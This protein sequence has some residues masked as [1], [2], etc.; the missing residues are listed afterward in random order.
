MQ[1]VLLYLLLTVLFSCNTKEKGNQKTDVKYQDSLAVFDFINQGNEVYKR[2]DNN[3]SFTESMDWYDKA[4]TAAENS[5]DSL[6]IAAA[7]YAKGRAYDALNTNPQKT[8]DYFTEAARLYAKFPE[9]EARALYIKHLVAHSYDKVNDSANCVN[10]LNNLFAEINNKPDSI[11]QKYPFTAEMALISTVVRNYN[12]ADTILTNL[13]KRQWIKNDS[14]EY[15]YVNHYY[16]TKARIDVFGKKKKN[17]LYLDSLQTVLRQAK[18]LSDSVFYSN[19]LVEMYEQIGDQNKTNF[20]LRLYQNAYNK[21]H[22]PDKLRIAEDKLSKLET[23]RIEDKRK[24]AEDAAEKRQRYNFFLVGL[25]SIISIL[26]VF[27]YKRNVMV[28]KKNKETELLNKELGIK[29]EQNEFLNKEIHH[30]VKN[31]LQMVMSLVEMEERHTES[32]EVK[33]KMQNIGLR[34]ESIS[35][36]HQQLM[37]QTDV[38][39]LKEYIGLIVKNITSVI[40]DGKKLILNLDVQDIRVPKKISLPL[41]L[42]INEWITNSIKYAQ[43]KDETIELKLDIHNGNNQVSVNYSDNGLAAYESSNNNGLG[44]KIIK[45]LI[46]QLKAQEI[47]TEHNPFE[48]KLKIPITNEE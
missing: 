8:I 26:S 41:G 1:K 39:N 33:E 30:R 42:L 24:A 10:T 36:L 21:F 25:L 34:I 19:E 12:L 47:K 32:D 6:L 15:D 44:L 20:F 35:K 3:V 31:N 46:A 38:V 40:G 13:T 7:I 29:N 5:G 28:K 14:T 27:L 2:K 9:K 18:N 17:S 45:I 4:Q 11:K 37:E 23:Q 16:L 22:S 48:Y 43:T